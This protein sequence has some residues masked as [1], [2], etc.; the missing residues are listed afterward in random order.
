M[1]ETNY[2]L[3]TYEVFLKLIYFKLLQ[4]NLNNE[5]I[6]FTDKTGEEESVYYTVTDIQRNEDGSCF[7]SEAPAREGTNWYGYA[8]CKDLEN[9]QIIVLLI[10]SIECFVKNV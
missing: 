4:E 2:L 3:Q 6:G 1:K 8:G 9:Q 10:H 5:I 7:I